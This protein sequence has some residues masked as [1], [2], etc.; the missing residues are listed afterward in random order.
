ME[1]L[2]LSNRPAFQVAAGRLARF[3]GIHFYDLYFGKKELLS[4][5]EP[6][7]PLLQIQVRIATAEDLDRIIYRIGGGIQKEFDHNISISS[8]CYVA[9]HEGNISGYLWLNQHIINLVGMQVT[10]LPPLSSFMHGVFVFP[11]HRRKKIFQLLFLRACQDMQ[12]TGFVSIT[13]LVDRAN[14]QSVEAFKHMGIGF[15]N[16]PILKL[17]GIKP[18][19]LN[20]VLE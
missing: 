20:K 19:V 1:A 7:V 9:V 16:A 12:R 6:V 4:P 10:R 5:P 14:K 8:T 2:P 11:E 18:L 15:Q 13:C 17:P 3:F